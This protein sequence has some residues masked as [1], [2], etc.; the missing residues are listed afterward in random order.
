MGL[1]LNAKKP[2]R[3]EPA[4]AFGIRVGETTRG[5]TNDHEEGNGI[6]MRRLLPPELSGRPWQAWR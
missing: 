4:A 6:S 3:N 5:E 2:P 1:S